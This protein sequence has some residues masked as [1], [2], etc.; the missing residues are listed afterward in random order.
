MEQPAFPPMAPSEAFVTVA[1]A[2]LTLQS[3]SEYRRVQVPPNRY[4]PL[5][6]QW[7]DIYS[8]IVDQMK[9]QIRM[10][11]RTRSVEIRV[12]P[13]SHPVTHRHLPTRRTRAPSKRPPIS[14]ER[15]FLA[16]TFAT[17]L[18]SS[19]LTICT[20]THLRSATVRPRDGFF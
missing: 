15:L 10:N 8:P 18:P 1:D 16:S 5:K 14:S 3:A 19:V 9:L 6:S 20:L 13:P 12:H 11:L 4:T 7:M 17:P 2:L